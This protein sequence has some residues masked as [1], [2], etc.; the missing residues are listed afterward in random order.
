M[1]ESVA[2]ERSARTGHFAVCLGSEPP[3]GSFIHCGDAGQHR[4]P[5]KFGLMAAETSAL[6]VGCEI[7]VDGLGSGRSCMAHCV[8]GHE[9]PYR[10]CPCRSSYHLCAG[11]HPDRESGCVAES[12][13]ATGNHFSANDRKIRIRTEPRLRQHAYNAPI[14]RKLVCI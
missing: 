12:D 2:D 13:I 6:R 1:V 3:A 8:A 7:C 11:Y 5:T 14:S 10:R 4:L 9:E